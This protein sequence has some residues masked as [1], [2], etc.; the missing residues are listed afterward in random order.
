[1]LLG[2]M[3]APSEASAQPGCRESDSHEISAYRKILYPIAVKL[4]RSRIYAPHIDLLT[5]ISIEIDKSGRLISSET[6]QRSRSPW[7]DKEVLL[8]FPV[9]LRLPPLPACGPE[10]IKVSIPVRVR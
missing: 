9:G 1:M 8:A 10:A 4:A 7:F 2:W 5:V 6:A 3:T